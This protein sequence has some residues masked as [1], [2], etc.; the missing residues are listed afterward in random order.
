MDPGW[1]YYLWA[2]LLVIACGLAWATN[3]FALPGN[4]IIVGLAAVFA[5]FLPAAE[6][7]GITW[8][9]VLALIVLATVGEIVEFFAGAAGAAKQGASRRS[10][11]L[12]IVGTVAGSIAGAMVSLPVPLIGP[13]LGAIGGGAAGAFVGAYVGEI[14]KGRTSE[15]GVAVGQGALIGRLLGTLGKLIVGGVMFVVVAVDAFVG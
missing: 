14:W 7:G 12:A 5:F 3:L 9:M 6:G 13:V 15:Q 11:V 8:W 1:L 10:V 2:L 4:W